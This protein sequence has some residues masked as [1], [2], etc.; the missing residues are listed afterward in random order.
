[1]KEYNLPWSQEALETRMQDLDTG[2]YTMESNLEIMTLYTRIALKASAK[3]VRAAKKGNF[4][5][6]RGY[7]KEIAYLKQRIDE[8]TLRS[9]IRKYYG[10]ERLLGDLI[11]KLYLTSKDFLLLHRYVTK[12]MVSYRTTSAYLAL[13]QKN[14]YK[15]IL[16]IRTKLRNKF[17]GL[18]IYRKTPQNGGLMIAFIG[19]DGS[20]KSTVTD[21]ILEWLTWKLDAKKFYLG[22]GEHYYSWQKNFN[23]KIR[24][25]KNCKI[26]AVVSAFLTLSNHI[27]V[28]RKTYKY[29]K[30]GKRF[31]S[32]GGIA[33]YDRYPQT[34][35]FGINDGPKIRFN[36]LDKIKSPLIKTIALYCARAEESYLSKAEQIMPDIVF[37]LILPPEISVERKPKENF[38]IVKKKHEII[39]KLSFSQAQ[40]YSIDVTQQYIEEIKEIKE[41]IWGNLLIPK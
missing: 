13:I 26:P 9:L 20:G 28:A 22:S 36:Y 10:S 24:N 39:K 25:I 5:L 31:A 6:D 23:K 18:I 16:P 4:K 37:K 1:M 17:N 41:L 30:Q 40:V 8:Q 15:V 33:I 11:T 7:L 14:Y 35:H 12:N 27:S 3:K 32:N 2:V 38:E 34:I 21:E 19:Q 29:V